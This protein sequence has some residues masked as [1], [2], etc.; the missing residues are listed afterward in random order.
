MRPAAGLALALL[1]G[2]LT[3]GAGNAADWAVVPSVTARSEFNSNLNYDFVAPKRDYIFTLA[4]T[5][6]FNYTTDLGQLQGRLGLTG[7][8]YLSNSQ[9]DHIDQN[10]Q[11][12]GRY[13]VAP[14]CSFSLNTAYISDSSLQEEF[15]TSGLIMTRTPRQSIQAGPAVT[16]AL[17]ERLAATVNYNFN[18]VNYQA[19]Q[20]QNFYSQQAGLRLEQQLKNEKTVLIGNFL[21]QESQYPAQDNVFRSLGFQLGGTHNFS[22]DWVVNLLGGINISFMEFQ[23]QVQDQAQS[24]F[25]VSVRQVA[26]VQQ[27]KTSPFVNLSLTRRW[28]Q[29]SITG[30][31]SRSQNA[32][33][34]GSVSDNSQVFLT[35]SYN[36]TERLSG[37]LNVNYAL[38]NQISNINTQQS[39]YFNVGPQLSYKLTEE[40]ALSPG[41]S[42]GLR[43]DI[44]GGQSAKAQTVFLMMTYTRLS[45]G[46]EKKPPTPVG[47]QPAT[48][49]GRERPA[50]MGRSP[51]QLY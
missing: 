35:L 27:T 36:F 17:T 15:L 45:V 8:H 23:T 38:A 13:Q 49:S 3:N 31:Y 40:L 29:F 48:L 51:F 14:R 5:A 7:L 10:F 2:I 6:E 12:N 18:K 26:K 47:S 19:Q 25:F 1:W 30:G 39:D 28:T 43:D 16:Y 24:P 20:L 22:P 9:I 4:P 32:S 34:Q 42:F 41:Y 11:I 50:A 21:A 46:S 37:S 33:A 44:T